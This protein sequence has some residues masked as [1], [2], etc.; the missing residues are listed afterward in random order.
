MFDYK[1][2]AGVI[3][4][5]IEEVFSRVA[6]EEIDRLVDELIG[7]EKVFIFGTG[8]TFMH[9]QSLGKRLAQMGFDCQV[10]GSVNEKPIGPGDVLLIA[11]ASGET[12]LPVEIARTAKRA[13]ARIA[14][15]TSP[16]ESTLKSL[17]DLAVHLPCPTKKDA[18]QGVMSVQTMSTLFGQC[19]LVLG[20]I[21]TMALQERK[22]LTNEDMKR[23]HANLE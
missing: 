21:I 1:N 11:S 3:L 13:G 19:L 6:V 17:S 5:E 4:N 12:R 20:D 7:A 9:L 8:R 15:I 16:T 10:V 14:L 23:F 22:G 18:S 2:A